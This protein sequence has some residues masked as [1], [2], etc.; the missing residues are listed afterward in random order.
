MGHLRGN[1]LEHAQTVELMELVIKDDF[2]WGSCLETVEEEGVL[3][4]TS[5]DEFV[6]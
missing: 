4:G 5:S 2:L 1:L 3:V 6:I